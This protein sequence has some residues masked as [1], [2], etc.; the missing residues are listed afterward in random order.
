MLKEIE[1]FPISLRN[2][3]YSSSVCFSFS[4]SFLKTSF[5]FLFHSSSVNSERIRLGITVSICFPKMSFKTIVSLL[6]RIEA[7]LR[8]AREYARR[9]ASSFKE[10]YF[11]KVML[12]N[13][14][15]VCMYKLFRSSV[16]SF[17]KFISLRTDVKIHLLKMNLGVKTTP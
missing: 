3:I 6:Q 16:L 1:L 7:L 12:L 11:L 9:V 8:I 4:S 17:E 2:M 5:I 15:I 10:N 13:S 14:R